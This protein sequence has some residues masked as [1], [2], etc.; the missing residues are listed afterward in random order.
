MDQNYLTLMKIIVICFSGRP[1]ILCNDYFNEKD[2]K[3]ILRI[4]SWFKNRI[5]IG[6]I[7]DFFVSF[8]CS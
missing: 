8:I 7:P 2:L 4:I 6:W 1:H 3:K 5:Y